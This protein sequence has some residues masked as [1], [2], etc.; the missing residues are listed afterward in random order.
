MP[1]MTTTPEPQTTQTTTGT[2]SGYL[3]VL[4][5][6]WH[7]GVVATG[8]G[9]ARSGVSADDDGTYTV[10]FL[11]SGER[12]SRSGLTFSE[13]VKAL[14]AGVKVLDR[15]TKGEDEVRRAREEALSVLGTQSANAN[16]DPIGGPA[17]TVSRSTA[18]GDN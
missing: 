10:T 2:R 14:A 17:P 13:A 3:P 11:G 4:P 18:P 5:D 6:G 9:D 15:V 16:E 8:P 12:R 7:Y 1:D